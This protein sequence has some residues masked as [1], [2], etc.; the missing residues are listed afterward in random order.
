MGGGAVPVLIP[1]AHAQQAPIPH[2]DG[3]EQLFPRLG[4]DRSFAQ[5]HGIGVDIVVD[6]GKLF[7]HME[8]HPLDNLLHHGLPAQ[9]GKALHQLHVVDVLVEQRSGDIGQR[10]GNGG[11][12][13]VLPP[14]QLLLNLLLP[15]GAFISA[16]TWDS[17]AS[18]VRLRTL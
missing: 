10:F 3:D 13:Q 6:S 1:L 2:V 16:I 12:L 8:L 4:R 5:D 14:L 15:A 11:L 18:S 7:L 9:G 17:A